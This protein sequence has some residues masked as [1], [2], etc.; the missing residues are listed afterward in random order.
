MATKRKVRTCTVNKCGNKHYG[1][2][3]CHKHYYRWMKHGDPLSDAKKRRGSCTLEGCT[4][5]HY[6]NGYCSKHYQRLVKHGD[7]HR[8]GRLRKPV[9]LCSIDGCEEIH[10]AR[11][12]CKNHHRNFLNYGDPLLT[13]KQP[14]RRGI[15]KC[16]V[17]GCDD[18]YH[19]KGL[20]S[21]H[22]SRLRRHGTTDDLRRKPAQTVA[23][24][25]WRVNQYG[26]VVGNLMGRAVSQHRILWEEHHGR[27]L[28]RHENLHHKNGI[29]HD[30]R[31]E[32]LELWAEPQPTGQRPEDLVAWVI[33]HY[34]NMV[35]QQMAELKKKKVKQCA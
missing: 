6:G 21:T 20:C 32:N 17:P 28:E 34:P 9:R 14:V 22:Y 35:K 16:A 18:Y 2:G 29:R 10:V 15:T 30:N 1:H 3:Y 24:V 27:K 12:Y 25:K 19:V 11:G 4:N 8:E 23:D 13:K 33:D 5:P 26:Y 31:I 7:L